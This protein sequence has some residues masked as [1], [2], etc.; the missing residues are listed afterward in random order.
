MFVKRVKRVFIKG[1]NCPL[2]FAL[3]DRK[4]FMLQPV[5]D[6]GTQLEA[7]FPPLGMCLHEGKVGIH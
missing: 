2:I 6:L 3:K 4:A 5:S 7:G 1:N